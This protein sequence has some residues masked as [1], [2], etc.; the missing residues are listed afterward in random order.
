[1][2][3]LSQPVT[4]VLCRQL[5][6]VGS[7]FYIKLF[8]SILLYKMGQQSKL[9]ES[10]KYK[11]QFWTDAAKHL[12]HHASAKIARAT[13]SDMLIKHSYRSRQ[14][15]LSSLPL[16]PYSEKE[17]AEYMSVIRHARLW[18]GTGRYQYSSDE[19][20]DV[21]SQIM[22]SG[23]LRP[24]PDAYAIMLG[25][26]HM[27]SISATPL[28]IIARSYADIHGKGALEED[29]FGSSMWWV[30]Y[31]YGSFYAQLFTKHIF[32]IARQYK[33]WHEATS[34][35]Q[36]ERTWGK[37]V[38]TK[39]KHVW[40]VFGLGSDITDNYPIL[41]GIK[42]Q[43]DLAAIPDAIAKTEVRLNRAVDLHDFTHIE[44]PEAKVT[45]TEAIIGRS[46][47]S[48]RVFPIELG[49]YVAS[50]Q[51]IDSLLRT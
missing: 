13:K 11:R 3:F 44:V 17:V 46:G 48:I 1:M 7:W 2:L 16:K 18:H 51:S 38:N 33:K 32:T 40:D 4:Y 43:A 47:H 27:T 28:R 15:K 8:S 29:R 23:G 20:V 34:N 41:L 10:D 49:E 31:Y 5:V 39:A 35:T 26:E 19:V 21:L 24:V 37:K 25:G 6:L 50:K 42:H 30:S 45:E 12:P 22:I 14:E 9:S 36:G